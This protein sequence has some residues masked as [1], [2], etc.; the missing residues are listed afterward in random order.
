MFHNQGTLE[1]PLAEQP[2]T[3]DLA[4]L[5]EFHPVTRHSSGAVARVSLCILISAYPDA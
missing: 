3:A 4:D 5:D 2:D 1:P